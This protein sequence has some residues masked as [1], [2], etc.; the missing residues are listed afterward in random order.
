MEITIAN[1][2]RLRGPADR[3]VDFL[4]KELRTP[5]PKYHEAI[6]QGFQA[7]GIPP[8]LTN[9]D[10]LSDNSILIPRGYRER[11]LYLIEHF[12]VHVTSVRDLRTKL[13]PNYDIDSSK[14]KLRPYQL[15]ALIELTSV[16]EEGIL[17][18][19]AGSGKTV[20]GISLIPMF[21]QKMLW[22]THTRPLLNQAID[23]A[24][25]FLPSLDAQ[26]IGII[27]DGKWQVGNILTVATVQTLVRRPVEAH[28]LRDEFGIVILDEAH[29]APAVTFLQVV[30]T[31]NPL[32]LY[33][34]TA[35]EERRDK[36]E[37]LM[38]QSIGPERSRVS[39][40][41]VR[42]Y[43]GIIIP[44]VVAR[45]INTEHIENEVPYT[46]ILKKL[47]YDKERN[48]IIVDDVLRAAEQ[49][50]KCIVVTD[51]KIHAEILFKMISE[52][53][54]KTGIAT[55]N[56]SK[57]I[58]KEQIRKL[59]EEEI[60]VLISTTSL[61]GE[62]FDYAPLNRCFL[63]LPFRNQTKIEQII[64]RIQR[65]SEGKRDA[66]LYDYVD[67]HSLLQHQFR[68]RGKKGCRYNV[69]EKLGADVQIV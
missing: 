32:Y 44:T 58:I 13:K 25:S 3:L 14:I 2:I 57:K 30:G 48:Q 36:L 10:L 67:N 54:Q 42:K 39:I 46:T 35:T 61:L 18:A 21:G 9:F 20:M 60:S 16:G 40:D 26:D 6:N 69:Y 38:F 52:H 24:A 51:R 34:L 31:F 17:I 1:K 66:V 8:F 62:G 37:T 12:K 27:G 19:P 41:T 55:G 33:G 43:G 28:K 23:R 22:L 64:G 50:N 5:N 49:G 29:H 56:Y 11:L 4:V 59:E 65:T 7:R 47:V 15:E 45:N 68:N 63:G 53:W